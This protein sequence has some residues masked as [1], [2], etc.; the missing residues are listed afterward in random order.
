MD[1]Y[2]IME[3]ANHAK[4]HLYLQIMHVLSK[5]VYP[6]MSTD[7]KNAIKNSFKLIMIVN[8]H[9]AGLLINSMFVL[10]ASKDIS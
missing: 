10:N 7:A 9:F 4:I 6:T 2:I 8:F 1:V 5:A 3:D